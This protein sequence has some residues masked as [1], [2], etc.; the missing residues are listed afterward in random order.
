MMTRRHFLNASAT[1]LAFA[2]SA[3]AQ[4]QT[5]PT[6]P[7]TMIVPAAPGGP[8]DVVGRL[9]AERM[10]SSLGQPIII[11]N[12]SGADGT[13]GMGRAARARPDGY[14]IDVGFLGQHVLTGA[15]Y[16]LQ[17]DVLNDF[18]PVSSLVTNSLVFF[19]R[20]T[21]PAK[22]MKE[23]IAWLKANP[24]KASAGTSSA[25]LR[26]EMAFFQKETGTHFALV[27][28]RG[29]A[30]M[31]QDLV[32]GEI[33]LVFESPVQLPLVRAG[34]IKAYAVT[35]DARITVAPDIPTFA[36]LGLPALCLL[37]LVRAFR[38]QGY[39]ER[40]HRQTQR[41]GRGGTGRSSG[42]ISARRTR[43]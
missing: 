21:L 39:A 4:A 28:Y 19:A 14:T 38:A 20:K 16:S 31:M 7:I 9:L 25:G 1:G 42:A 27:P 13:I 36:E 29:S 26:L 37:R 32:A 35:S 5:Y 24:N 17:Y 40:H 22:D 43:V 23:L 33:D 30:P 12:V 41:G 3:S 34:S 18:A 10:K 2:V 15:F 8:T 6:R 11:E